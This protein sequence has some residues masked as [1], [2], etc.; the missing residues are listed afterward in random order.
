MSFANLLEDEEQETATSDQQSGR[1][2]D[3]LIADFV[4]LDA[5]IKAAAVE[6]GEVGA[7]LAQI[8]AGERSG[9]QNTVHLTSTGGQKVKCEFKTDTE[10]DNAQMFTAADLLGKDAFDSLFKT[11]VEFIAQKRNLKVFMNTVHSDEKVKT[12]KQVIKDA[13][14]T[15][16]KTPYISVEKK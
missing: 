2:Q 8:A 11:N 14:I 16:V 9:E 5:V 1:S 13:T 7:Q 10:Y 3:E 4:R 15:K 6:R 12:A